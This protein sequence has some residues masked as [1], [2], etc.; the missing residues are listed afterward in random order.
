MSGLLQVLFGKKILQRCV[1]VL[2]RPY[3]FGDHVVHHPEE[4]R[5]GLDF[6]D[7]LQHV[8]HGEKPTAE[9]F[10]KDLLSEQELLHETPIV[11]VT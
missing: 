8:A 10:A 5:H 3:I 11:E 2:I 9:L 1:K 6:H 4:L 7:L